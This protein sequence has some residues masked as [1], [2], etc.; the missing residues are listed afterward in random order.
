LPL[1]AASGAAMEALSRN[2]SAEFGS[3]GI[4]S[5]CLRSTGIPETG[6]IDISFGIHAKAMGISREQFQSLMEGMTH[7]RRS[8]TLT[9]LANA[10]VFVASDQACGMTV[11][12]V[13]LTGGKSST[14]L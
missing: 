3:Q 1:A 4:R 6:T 12:V 7:T 9:E 8:T 13:N 11:A 14:S 10:A 2:L 5:I